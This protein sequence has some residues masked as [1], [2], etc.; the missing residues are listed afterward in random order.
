[1][2]LY[3]Q[4]RVPDLQAMVTRMHM[5]PSRQRRLCS[6]PPRSVRTLKNWSRAANAA[7]RPSLRGRACRFR[8][9]LLLLPKAR[10]VQ[11]RALLLLLLLLLD[12]LLMERQQQ[13]EAGAR[14]E[15]QL[16]QA[17]AV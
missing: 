16:G 5:K 9:L 12:P 6:C 7:M 1:V 13:A 4:R 10:L 15:A 3:V 2:A 11:V 8:W 17:S 14:Q